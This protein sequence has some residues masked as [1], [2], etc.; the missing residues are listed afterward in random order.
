[1]ARIRRETSDG[2]GQGP[3]LLAALYRAHADFVWRTLL[4]FG[5]PED[6]AE[7]VV[8][9]VFLVARRRLDDFD[10]AR[11]APSTWLYGLSRGVAAN[12][13]RAHRRAEQRLAVVDAPLPADDPDTELARA[14]ASAL[15]QRFV[16]ELEPAQ[17]EVFVLCDIE[18]LRGPEVAVML[19]QGTNQV[20]SRLRLAR[21]R[22]VAFLAE[23]GFAIAEAEA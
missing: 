13:R 22:F 12:W 17:R 3:P 11:A 5:I 9:E 7:D 20:Y 23:H 14:Q 19:G 16:A 10:P 21:R 6:A 8:H 15:V 1:M 18:G 4:R 2:G